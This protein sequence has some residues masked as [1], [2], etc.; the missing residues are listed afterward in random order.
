M[1]QG[2]PL[3]GTEA[4]AAW[5]VG[6]RQPEM[7]RVAVVPE[8]RMPGFRWMQ[9]LAA[10]LGFDGSHTS[11]MAL[12][13][14]ILVRA[15]DADNPRLLL[16]ECVH[17]A[18]YER[19]GSLSGFLRRYLVECLRDGYACSTLEREASEQASRFDV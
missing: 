14:G 3:S 4:A 5:A 1:R 12:R 17:T 9:R 16:H 11:G 13:Y 6:V 19:I 10:R 18:Q 15:D 7:I 2:R 8:V